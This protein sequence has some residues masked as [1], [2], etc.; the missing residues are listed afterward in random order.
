MSQA[1]YARD[2][3][4]FSGAIRRRTREEANERKHASTRR[5]S[6]TETLAGETPAHT[7]TQA[8]QTT[9]NIALQVIIPDS[10]HDVIENRHDTAL[11][12]HP[13]HLLVLGQSTVVSLTCHDVS[14]CGDSRAEAWQQ[15]RHTAHARRPAKG[16]DQNR[17][18]NILSQP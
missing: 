17:I 14:V 2:I 9:E 7:H 1:S 5:H 10:H 12:Y 16:P 11:H 3:Y 4:A 8:L 18:P 6:E 15:H 13:G